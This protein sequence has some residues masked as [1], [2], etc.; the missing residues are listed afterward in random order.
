MLVGEALIESVAMSVLVSVTSWEFDK[1]R[2]IETLMKLDEPDG[3]AD[4]LR[5]MDTDR[6][7]KS[8]VV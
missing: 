2:D 4:L 5:L 8:V 7:S 3:V 6:E 1:V